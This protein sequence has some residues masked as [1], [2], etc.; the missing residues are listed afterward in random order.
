MDSQKVDFFII[1]NAKYF[2]SHHV[3][4]IRDKLLAID[5]SKW[6]LIQ[7]LQFKDPTLIL[8][9]SLLAGTLGIDRFIIGDTGLGVGNPELILLL[10]LVLRHHLLDVLLPLIPLNGGAGSIKAHGSVQH[11]LVNQ[12]PL[13]QGGSDAIGFLIEAVPG[14]QF[15]MVLHDEPAAG[16]GGQRDGQYYPGGGV[17]EEEAHA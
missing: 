9:V 3:G 13:F 14:A 15:R 11:V 4:I 6:A 16:T 1:T 17:G 10:L 12:H 8:V 2:E 7:T 5:D